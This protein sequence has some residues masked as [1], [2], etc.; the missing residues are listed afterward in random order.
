MQRL[1]EKMTLSNGR[2][3][4]WALGVLMGGA[5]LGA[6]ALLVLVMWWPEWVR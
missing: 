3:I 6:G 5:L 4:E 2:A 1:G